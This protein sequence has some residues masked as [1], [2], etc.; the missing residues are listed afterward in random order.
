MD[1]AYGSQQRRDLELQV[2]RALLAHFGPHL[3]DLVQRSTIEETRLLVRHGPAAA[4]ARHTAAEDQLVRLRAVPG[5]GDVAVPV[6]LSAGRLHCQHMCIL[7]STG[8]RTS[9]AQ[10]A[11]PSSFSTAPAAPG[12]PTRIAVSLRRSCRGACC[13]QPPRQRLPCFAS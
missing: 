10:R 12:T 2:I 13:R 6:E 11:S 8:C 5:S 3:A 9:I 4:A 7:H 1:V